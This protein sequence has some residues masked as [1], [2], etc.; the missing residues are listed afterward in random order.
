MMMSH[1]FL[2]PPPVDH[3]LSYHKTTDA[4]HGRIEEREVWVCNDVSW[5]AHHHF[6]HLSSIIRI[7][8]RR[9]EKDR[10]SEEVRYYI[11]SLAH[12]DAAQYGDIIRQHWGVETQ[13]H[14][15]LDMAFDEDR[16]RIRQEHADENMATLRH[17]ALNL[18]KAEKTAKVGLKIKRQMAG[19]DEQYLLKI[20]NQ[21]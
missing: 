2:T 13:L 1:F 3:E 20:L 19:W 11:S 4:D 15:C 18:L 21:F 9:H 14:F 6:P 8:A 5:L 17:L 7:K 10:W 16:C 12:N